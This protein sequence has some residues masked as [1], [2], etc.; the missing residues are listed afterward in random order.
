MNKIEKHFLSLLNNKLITVNF[1]T[2]EITSHLTRNPRKVGAKQ[3]AGYLHVGHMTNGK[4]V[5]ILSHRLIWLAAGNDV[6]YG[7]EINH[8][9]GN[10]QDNRLSNLECV[11]RSRN[12]IHAHEELGLIFGLFDRDN[13]GENNGRSIMTWEKVREM[14]QLFA[15]GRYT[16]QALADKFGIKKS[17]A[18][19]ILLGYQWIESS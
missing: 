4:T 17:Q 12:T 10:K 9:N 18:S 3:S 8:K 2:G 6:P 19:N 16:K 5:S 7:Y 14:R 11:T 13:T 15:T 1:E